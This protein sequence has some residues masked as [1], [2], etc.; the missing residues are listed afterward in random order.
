MGDAILGRHAAHLLGKVPGPWA[1]VN[2][3]KDVA[4]NVNHA[5]AI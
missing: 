2:F 1:I 3:R 5:F 4:V